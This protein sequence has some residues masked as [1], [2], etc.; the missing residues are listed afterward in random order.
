M[1]EKGRELEDMDS[2]AEAV[3][4]GAIV[5]YYLS[6]SRIKDISFMLEDALSF[7]GNTGPYAQYT[8]ARTCSILSRADSI[9]DAAAAEGAPVRC[10]A[11]AAAY[12][13]TLPGKGLGCA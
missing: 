1:T 5:Y 9:P 7:D 3:G 13:C 12:A 10:G 11:R 2:V 4:V 6:G 8:Y